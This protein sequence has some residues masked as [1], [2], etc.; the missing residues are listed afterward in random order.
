MGWQLIREALAEVSWLSCRAGPARGPSV[1]CC[2]RGLQ[3]LLNALSCLQCAP[4]KSVSGKMHSQMA[5]RVTWKGHEPG[6]PR[7]LCPGTPQE[8]SRPGASAAGKGLV[9]RLL[10]C[11]HWTQSK[12]PIPHRPWPSHSILRSSAGGHTLPLPSCCCRYSSATGASLGWAQKEI[13]MNDL[14][15]VTM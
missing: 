15:R 9:H 14:A 3:I 7:A 4:K 5:P 2:D 10:L 6:H 12:P 8:H 1:S 13:Q 11:P